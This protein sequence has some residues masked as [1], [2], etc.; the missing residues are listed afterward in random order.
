MLTKV[1]GRNKLGSLVDRCVS[2][3]NIDALANLV[4]SKWSGKGRPPGN[5]KSEAKAKKIGLIAKNEVYNPEW[6]EQEFG[7]PIGWT[8]PQEQRAATQL[9]ECDDQPLEISSTPDLPRSACSSASLSLSGEFSTSTHSVPIK[10]P[11]GE[12]STTLKTISLWQ[13]WASLIPLGLKHYETRN[14]KTN[15]RGKLLICSTAANSKQHKEYLKIC[16]ELQLPAWENFPHGSAIALCDLVDCIEMTPEF[17]AQQ[18]Q[19]EIKSGDWQVGRYA[20]KLENIQPI[21][22]AFAVKGKQGFFDVSLE[23]Y[24]FLKEWENPELSNFQLPNSMEVDSNPDSQIPNLKIDED[25]RG[26]G[27]SK[28]SNQTQKS[29]KSKPS[30][31]CYTPPHIVELI[32]RVLGTIDLDPCADDGKHIDAQVHYTAADDGLSKPWHGRIF[33]NPP[34]SCPGKWVTW[35]LQEYAAGRVMEAIALLP[36]ATDTNWMSPLLKSQPVCFW[37]GRIKFL[38][39]NYQPMRSGA[40]QSHVFVYWGENVQRFREVF[41]DYGVVCIPTFLNDRVINTNQVLGENKSLLISPS[42]QVQVDSETH[43]N[44]SSSAINSSNQVSND[45]EV[46]GGNKSPSIS[47]STKLQDDSQTHENNLFSKT[48]S[49]E[50]VSNDNQVLGENKSPLISPSTHRRHG[51]G[52]G[53]LLWGYANANSSKKKPVK[54]L[55]F[56]WEYRGKR[57]KTY[58]RLAKLNAKGVTHLKEQVI[59]MNEAKVP[60]VEILELLKYN[61]KVKYVLDLN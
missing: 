42:T 56:E 31:R 15:Y 27:N 60:V 20:W 4:I 40:R 13:P 18:S 61:P 43:R 57:G 53:N 51:E 25:S 36:A 16:D 49:S 41:E 50:Q 22:E 55:Y 30:D 54:Q 9:L 23:N 45:D 32:V 7:L 12:Y 6:L 10:E 38:D 44:S 35:F 17:I 26:E 46:L 29:P 19:T 48:V 5:T 34:Y 21:T 8:D 28:Q 58:V 39:E 52:S 2:A 24:K 47:P 1:G 59:E 3:V 33:F 14:W 37:K 11:A